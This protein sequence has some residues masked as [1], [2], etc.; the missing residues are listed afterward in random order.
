MNANIYTILMIVA[1]SLSAVFLIVAIILFFKLKIKSV[2]D[3]LSGRKSRR[4]VAEIRKENAATKS[5]GYVPGIFKENNEKITGSLK[6]EATGR[7]K[8]STSK[9]SAEKEREAIDEM[10]DETGGTVV[11]STNPDERGFE[12]GTTVLNVTQD[13]DGTTILV[14]EDEGTTLLTEEGI[15]GVSSVSKCNVIREFFVMESKEY[16]EVR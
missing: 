1:F 15:E 8:R 4:Q 11:L 3:E 2:V 13:S 5:R 14:E 16:L 7:M 12:E 9:L 10:I 6:S